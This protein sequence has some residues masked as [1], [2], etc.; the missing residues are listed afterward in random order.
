M[1]KKIILVVVALGLLVLSFGAGW[2]LQ[3]V[4]T[5]NGYK[6]SVLPATS[7]V[8][9]IGSGEN[10]EA[11]YNSTSDIY[12]ETT[13]LDEFIAAVAP[14]KGSIASNSS[15]YRGDTENISSFTLVKVDK[16]YDLTVG[17]AKTNGKWV[18]TSISVNEQQRV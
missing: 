15:F 3:S 5:E 1:I 17:T 11:A 13:T 12:K 7:I 10:L 18:I 2:K 6:N 16:T 8:S 14:L 9:S 4:Q